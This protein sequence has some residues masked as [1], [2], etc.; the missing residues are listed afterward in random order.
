MQNSLV[1]S[2]VFGVVILILLLM[3]INSAT[4][5]FFDITDQNAKKFRLK[6]L[7]KMKE[8]EN[9]EFKDIMDKI[10]EKSNA[11]LM[12]RLKRLLPSIGKID[13]VQLKR[14]LVLANWDDTF[15]PESFIACVW[16]LRLV[17]IVVLPFSIL[18][19][20][21]EL[22]VIGAIIGVILL[23]GLEYWFNSSVKS[24]K[25]ELFS[26]FPDF[27]RIVS[28]Y[29]SAD[30]P[31]VQ[32]ITDSIRYV[33][34]AWEPILKTFVI[35]CE[36][37]SVDFALDRMKNTVDLFEVREFISLIKLTLE[38][39]GN[40]KDGFLDQADKIEELQRNQLVLKV[41]KRKMMGQLAQ[42]PL[43]LINMVIIALPTLA[44]A[45]D[46]FSGGPMSGSMGVG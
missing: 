24:V 17:G 11:S 34:D 28:G 35:D 44:Q 16:A 14:D 19:L 46:M 9:V 6:Q 41:G 26:E 33:G 18:V 27:I 31:L 1:I 32:S 4:N 7:Q 5:L 39:G 25:E 22:R 45:L 42:A 3:I 23:V 2:L 36:N 30:I 21:N 40:A 29:L 13:T 15:T 8:K 37:K 38:Q 10:A 12:P 20:K 43:L